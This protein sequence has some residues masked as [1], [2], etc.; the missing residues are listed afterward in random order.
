M[1]AGFL[2]SLRTE[3]RAPIGRHRS[4]EHGMTISTLTTPTLG[5]ISAPPQPLASPKTRRMACS[6]R[7]SNAP[8]GS[9]RTCGS[10]PRP[11]GSSPVIDRPVDR[12]LGHYI[13]TLANQRAAA[14]RRCTGHL[15]HRRL[16]G[17]RRP[18]A[19]SRA[20]GRL[21]RRRGWIPS[22]RRSSRTRPSQRAAAELPGVHRA[23]DSLCCQGTLVLVG[24]DQLPHVELA[25]VIARRFNDRYGPGSKVM[26]RTPPPPA[27]P[28]SPRWSGGPRPRPA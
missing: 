21:P 11:T 19:G 22:G 28:G 17:D 20:G 10:I 24:K 12:R 3:P 27:P 23:A 7:R 6:E 16:S 4:K 13:G 26:R 1:V 2:V 5:A 14:E 18:R 15:R 9:R 25:R 8:S